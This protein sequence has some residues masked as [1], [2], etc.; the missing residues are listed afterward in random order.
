MIGQAKSDQVERDGVA[1]RAVVLTG[2]ESGI[3][4]ATA[5]LLARRGAKVLIIGIQKKRLDQTVREI[6]AVGEVSGVVADV[7]QRRDV[8]KAFREADRRLGG[9]DVLINN[10]AVHTPGIRDTSFEEAKRLLE[11]NVLGYFACTKLAIERMEKKGKG[12]IVNVGSI[13]GDVRE[14]GHELYVASK[15][16]VEG[17]TESLGKSLAKQGIRTTV[18]EPGGVATPLLGGTSGRGRKEMDRMVR[19]KEILDPGDMAEC[20]YYVLTQPERC[21]VALVQLRPAKNFT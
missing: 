14:P 9:V 20:I 21:D 18:I 7:S 13:S 4:K 10:A 1:G 15:A 19:R 12:H 5:M 6:G 17:L 11:V 3:G 2:G 16:A 8:E